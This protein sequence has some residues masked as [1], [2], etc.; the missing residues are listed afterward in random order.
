[1]SENR[2]I[3]YVLFNE[4]DIKG[5]A[6][7]GDAVL[8][9][10]S[11]QAD[12]HAPFT[13]IFVTIHFFGLAP[14]W[15]LGARINV[16]CEEFFLRAEFGVVEAVC[17]P[18]DSAEFVLVNPPS[19]SDPAE[20]SGPDLTPSGLNCLHCGNANDLQRLAAASAVYCPRCGRVFDIYIA[21]SGDAIH[22]FFELSYAQ[23]LTIPRSVL[24]S[25]PTELQRRLAQ[26]L[27]EIDDLMD[28]R[29]LEGTRYRVQLCEVID[30]DDGEEGWG[31]EVHDELLDYDR[32]RR[33]LLQ[34]TPLRVP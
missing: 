24:Q 22:E 26:C 25:L 30:G 32:G 27:T 1:M 11:R 6:E 5:H 14:S 21:Q 28:W 10:L 17:G 23:F 33:M 12:A 34:H 8:M 29:P 15:Q 4:N 31:G 16:V 13:V 3:R 20:L 7:R 9:S 18:G 2:E 19:Y